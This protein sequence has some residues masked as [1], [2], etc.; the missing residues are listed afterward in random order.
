MTDVDAPRGRRV[1]AS[2][3]RRP[4]AA[5]VGIAIPLVLYA[6]VVLSGAHL[7]HRWRMLRRTRPTRSGPSGGSL[8][9]S[10]PT[11]TSL[12]P[13]RSSPS[14]RPATRPIRCSSREP[15]L[16]FQSRP[17]SSPSRCCSSRT[18][19][20]VWAR[21]CQMRSSSRPCAALRSALAGAHTPTTATPLRRHHP[22]G[23]AGVR[24]SRCSP[25]LTLWGSLTT[26]QIV[27]ARERR[28]SFLLL[29]HEQ[30]VGRRSQPSGAAP[31]GRPGS[32]AAGGI[33]LARFGTELRPLV[34][35][36]RDPARP[37]DGAVSRPRGSAEHR[38]RGARTARPA[39]SS[40][41][42]RRSGRTGRQST[43]TLNTLYPAS[44]ARPA[45]MSNAWSMFGAPG[46]S[47]CGRRAPVILNQ[48][49]IASAYTL[50]GYGH[51]GCCAAACPTP[52]PGCAPPCG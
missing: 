8:A 35:H 39:A 2:P 26:G 9:T 5:V 31:D 50:C 27:V 30:W 3:I 34:H 46:S 44:A 24:A 13:R 41:S 18:T 47:A 37:R 7:R 52:R 21:C 15:D 23:V 48:P 38:I 6:I 14:W 29:A 25:P 17:A 28:L 11:S 36:H 40:Y 1:A 20:C 4:R 49:E 22:D 45:A 16:T 43:P 32:A 33:L 42:Q 19:C 10:A 12:S 51:C